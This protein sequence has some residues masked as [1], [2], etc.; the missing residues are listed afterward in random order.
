MDLITS[1]FAAIIIMGI[2]LLLW[3]KRQQPKYVIFRR[4]TGNDTSQP[5]ARQWI[6]SASAIYAVH[7]G[8]YWDDFV[9]QRPENGSGYQ[10][11]NLREL[12][13]VVDRQSLLY[14]LHGMLVDGHRGLLR[15]MVDYYMTLSDSEAADLLRD[16]AADVNL[17]ETERSERVWQIQAV[18]K[19]PDSVG[20]INF[21]AWDFVR[22]INVCR[23]GAAAN[24]FEQ[25]EAEDFALI[26]CHE[27]QKEFNGWNECAD[28]FLRARRFWQASDDAKARSDQQKFTD[29]VTALRKQSDSPWRLVSWNM[30]LP[31]PRWLFVSALIDVV[32]APVLSEKDR[33]HAAEV[34]LKLDAV[35][36]RMMDEQPDASIANV[37]PAP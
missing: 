32:L 36:R 3:K 15:A 25:D 7:H 12:G 19:N 29:A 37:S 1:L 14:Q 30:H 31:E 4:R 34:A 13:E 11:Q 16:I 24:L 17:D 5:D 8:E 26:A 10:V 9:Y 20:S 2:V 28:H 6:L 22:F 35:A 23:I 21:A 27:L 18:R 33:A